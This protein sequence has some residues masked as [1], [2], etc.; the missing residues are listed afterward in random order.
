[1]QL[2]AVLELINNRP[3]KCLGYLSP[4]EFICKLLH[5]D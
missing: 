4:N 5:L 3:R 1:M 2:D